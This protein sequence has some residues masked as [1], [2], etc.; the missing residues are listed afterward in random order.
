MNLIKQGL[1]KI[2]LVLCV[3]ALWVLDDFI[4]V[5]PDVAVWAII[6]AGL[7]I[8]GHADRLDG[9]KAYW[10]GEQLKQKKEE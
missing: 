1:A 7:K 5:L 4:P 9:L 3:I 2:G 10:T 8:A 6:G